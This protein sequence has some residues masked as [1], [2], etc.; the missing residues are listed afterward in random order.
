[1]RYF[2][3]SVALILVIGL[4]N[5]TA[6]AQKKGKLTPETK[7]DLKNA[8]VM[9]VRY[10]APPLRFM[11][12]KDAVGSGLIA[13]VTKS[14]LADSQERH[15]FYPSKLVQEN[16]DS[17][18]RAQGI[19]TNTELVPD[20]FEFHM[21][22]DLKDLSKYEGID[23][24]YVVEV[25][26]PLMG[27]QASYSPT[28]WRTYWLNLAVEVRIIRTSD[29]TRVWKA[30]VGHG[31]LNDKQLKFHI[32]ELEENGKEKIEHMLDIAAVE[33]SKKVVEHYAKAKK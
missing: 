5:A 9:I 12:P 7:E 15:R 33:S 19:I 17:L 26:V 24:D 3:V 20:A 29:L 21:P 2:P 1:M 10:E 4:T 22:A 16:V 6:L 32:T 11:T 30:N 13:D 25:I 28:K 27:W 8:K 23:A 31:G 14:D 18:L